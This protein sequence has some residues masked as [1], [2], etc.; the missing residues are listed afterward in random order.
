MGVQYLANAHYD[1]LPIVHEAF[2]CAVPKNISLLSSTINK[3]GSSGILLHTFSLLLRS[4]ET[5]D[6]S[7]ESFVQTIW[8]SFL[9]DN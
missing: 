6:I 2:Q 3:N 5:L 1:I 9:F 7:L 8:Q 4:Y